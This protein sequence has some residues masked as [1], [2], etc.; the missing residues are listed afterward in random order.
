MLVHTGQHY[1][2]AMSQQLFTEL[3]L[4]RPDRHLAL[5]TGSHGEMTGRMITALER[6]MVESRPDAVLVLGD[7][8]TTL[9]GAL[10]RR[11]AR[12]TCRPRRGGSA[13]LRHAHA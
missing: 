4:P 6:L 13:Q 3:R 2:V 7:T 9:A 12:D 11:Q 8:N 10:S 1:D 5:G